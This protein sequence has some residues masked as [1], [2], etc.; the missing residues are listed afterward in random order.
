METKQ[1]LSDQSEQPPRDAPALLGDQA[2]L[3]ATADRYRTL[4]SSMDAGYGLLHLIDD[5]HGTA[6]D[7]RILEVNPAFERETGLTDV[8]GKTARDLNPATEPSWPVL[9]DTVARTGEARRFEHYACGLDR[10]FEVYAARVGDAGSRTV[11]VVFTNITARK[12]AEAA[13]RASEARLHKVLDIA[14]VS[15]IFFTIDGQITDAN[16]AF[17]QMSGYSRADLAHGRVRWDTMTPPEWLPPSL[18]AIEEL[19]ARGYTTPYEKEYIRKDGTRWWA[20]FAARLLTADEGVEFIIDITARKAAEA[21]LHASEERLRL[22]VESVQDYAIFTIDPEGRVTS[23]NTG[24]RRLKGYT[25][26]EILGHPIELFYTPEDVAAGKPAHERATALQ[27]GRSEDES[28]RVRKDGARVWINEIMTPLYAK[29]GTHLGFT[30]ISRDLTARKQADAERERLLHHAEQARAEAEAALQVRAQFMGIASHELRTPLTS[31]LGYTEL[32]R[33][34]VIQGTRDR[35]Q[36][37]TDKIIRQIHRLNRLIDQLLDVSRLERGQFVIERQPVDLVA[38][39]KEVVEDVRTTLPSQ[40]HYTLELIHPT[41][42]VPIDGDAER[43]QQV[44]HNLLSNAVKYSPAGGPI[45]VQVAHAPTAVV[46]EVTDTG[47]GIPQD[48]QAHLFELFYRAPN[49]G[50]QLSGFGLGLHIVKEI[51]ERHGGR[52]AVE[53][54]EGAGATFRICLPLHVDEHEQ[55]DGTMPKLA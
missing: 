29:D 28:W 35:E 51:V 25:T 32:L 15:V 36:Q 3:P 52:I 5:P 40:P 1:E 33:G 13:L 41:G 23:W 50:A 6:V 47:I 38:L 34:S 20:L 31:M 14:T 46:L 54:S 18:H 45:R 30:K 49:V 11:A 12:Q 43:L 10:W 9:L 53:S 7:W 19:R 27:L 26:E 4:L 2:W 22:V 16:A 48:A 39:A 42:P 37:I 21:A 17:L 8:V 24:A 44:V 55:A